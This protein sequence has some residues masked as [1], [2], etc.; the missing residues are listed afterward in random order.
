[1]RTRYLYM[2][3]EVFCDLV[4]DKG[5]WTYSTKDKEIIIEVR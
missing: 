3:G 4:D 2:K 1:M 5:H